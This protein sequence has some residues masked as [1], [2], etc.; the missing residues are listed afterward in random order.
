M[1]IF[2]KIN[3]KSHTN[4]VTLS[5]NHYVEIIYQQLSSKIVAITNFIFCVNNDLNSIFTLFS[6]QAPTRL[7]EVRQVTPEFSFICKTGLILFLNKFYSWKT[8]RFQGSWSR[9]HLTIC[10]MITELSSLDCDSK[11]HIFPKIVAIQ[12]LKTVIS[13]FWVSNRRK[14]FLSHNVC[15]RKFWLI[16]GTNSEHIVYFRKC[17]VNLRRSK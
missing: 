12:K 13:L 8:T 11:N 1:G 16:I 14:Y 10:V 3:T 7:R 9:P 5:K 15:Y 17:I 6:I 2:I 4:I